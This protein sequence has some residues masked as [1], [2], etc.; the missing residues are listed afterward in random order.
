MKKLLQRFPILIACIFAFVLATAG[1]AAAVGG[2]VLLTGDDADDSGHCQ[3]TACG[4]LYAKALKFIVDN[5]QSAGTGILAIGVNSSRALIGFNSWNNT[6]NG[7]PG[8]A[9]THVRTTAEIANA[10][11]SNFAVIYIPSDSSNT[12]GGINSTQLSALNA[13][14]A[15]IADFVNQ[16]GG[17]LMALGS[18]MY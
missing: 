6:A 17:G 4:G 11:F 8:V 1:Q 14:Q 15:D 9:V 5:S 13:R 12:G 2:P 7:G 3:G 18:T 10:D 16:Q